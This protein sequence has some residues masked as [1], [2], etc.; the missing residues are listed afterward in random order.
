MAPSTLDFL[1]CIV[2]DVIES[3]QSVQSVLPL[4]SC[5]APEPTSIG[6]FDKLAPYPLQAID[7]AREGGH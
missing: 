4:Y 5:N 3:V 7:K 1:S 6:T 2:S